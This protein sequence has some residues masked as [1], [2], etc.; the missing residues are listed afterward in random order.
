MEVDKNVFQISFEL[1][2][3]SD[4]KEG[5]HPIKKKRL[6]VG[7]SQACDI[8]I[9]SSDVTAIHA[10]IEVTES[11]NKIYDMN[12]KNG[13]FINGDSVLTAN[14]KLGDTLKFASKE[15]S[16][17]KY[18]KEDLAPPPLDMLNEALPPIIEKSAS[19]PKAPSELEDRE[20][21][22][23]VPSVEYPLAKDPK[24]E[25]SEYIFED[26]EHLYPIFKYDVSKSAVE[27]I[28]L[29]K[30]RVY[31]VDYLPDRE[32]VYNLVGFMPKE[33]E[34]EYSYLGKDERVSLVQVEGDKTT[35]FP[36]P[37]YEFLS[38]S[39]EKANL[40]GGQID[41]HRDDILRFKNGDLQIF[42]RGDEAPP[43]VAPAPILRRDSGDLKKYVLLMLLLVFFFMGS[44]TFIE[45]DEEIEKDKVPE[46]IAKILYKKKFKAKKSPAIDKTKNANKKVVQKSNKLSQT[47][48][49]KSSNV[50]AD[51]N[52]SKTVTG[53]KGVK[54]AKRTGP[55]KKA[56]PNKGPK[57]VKKDIV[58]PTKKIGGSKTK[59]S[60]KAKP[61]TAKN[62]SKGRVDTYKSFNF[63][64]TVSN[65]LSK[66]GATS[67]FQ[68][69]EASSDM[70]APSIDAGSAPGATLK[71][72]NVSN[73]VGSLSGSARGKLDSSRGVEGLVDKKNI[74]TAGLPFKTVILGG[75]DPDIIRKIIEDHI[76]QFRYCYQKELD[77]A[78]REFSGVV[79]L[80]FIIGASGHVTKAGV[81]SFSPLPPR[82][83][84]CVVN[85]L[86]GIKFP[87]P[88]GGG[89]VEVNQ[90]FNFYPKRK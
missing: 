35:V 52:K 38:L 23:Y 54:T 21:A 41:L 57:N 19:L 75:M 69:K 89:V 9:D 13:T 49:T 48:S 77:K 66:G 31:S 65:L 10:V 82:V 86:K 12:S 85:V 64:S 83:K 25:F 44:L 47:K 72:A 6:L 4:G 29:Y 61:R 22:I 32:G 58:R 37:G 63:N 33:N 43:K 53:K 1:N 73:N 84:G 79:R 28:V 18:E 50:K 76:P 45:V 70:S 59:K 39:D 90:P 30:D 17:K 51:A 40:D 27:V 78:S 87:E 88:L 55:V 11:G 34:V 24:A 16:F 36:I 80:N 62:K 15:Y 20:T 14:F 67:T 81:D 8:V 2:P 60:G 3:L 7:R 56:T 46:R 42:V 74:Y 5:G 26:S 71:T 68:A